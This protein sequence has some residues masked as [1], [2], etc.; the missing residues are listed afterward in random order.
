MDKRVQELEQ[1]ERELVAA[2][3]LGQLPIPAEEI[4]RLEDAGWTVDLVTGTIEL[5]G[6]RWRLT[7]AGA[8]WV[9]ERAEGGAP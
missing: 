3:V 6:Q 2:G 8:A 5:D 9:L 1:L 7:A 4:V